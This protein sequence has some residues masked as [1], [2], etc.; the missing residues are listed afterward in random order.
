MKHF[1]AKIR[2][3]APDLP[4]EATDEEL[5]KVRYRMLKSESPEVTPQ[6]YWTVLG[7][8][9]GEPTD[10]LKT[11]P[12]VV[13]P[14]EG[15][16][17]PPK[18]AWE[19]A[20]RNNMKIL[21][22]AVEFGKQTIG[23]PQGPLVGIAKTAADIG[24][25]MA[26]GANSLITVPED[27]IMAL[28]GNSPAAVLQDLPT[29]DTKA[30]RERGYGDEKIAQLMG[31][32]AKV[33]NSLIEDIRVG[34]DK[35]SREVA[36]GVGLFL[37]FLA[38]PGAGLAVTKIGGSRLGSALA[39]S[40]AGGGG[41]MG[42]AAAASGASPEEV[43]TQTGTGALIGGLLHGAGEASGALVKKAYPG[44]T[45][46][47]T[48][49]PTTVDR[50]IP[51]P[52]RPVLNQPLGVNP[53]PDLGFGARELPITPETP[54]MG[55]LDPNSLVLPRPPIRGFDA[56]RGT[57]LPE[58]PQVVP[59]GLPIDP[60]LTVPE[61]TGPPMGQPPG[62]YEPPAVQGRIGSQP[63]P[64]V[65]PP[66][67]LPRRPNSALD[68]V[69]P[70]PE[71]Q[72][73]ARPI[74]RLSDYY[75]G[76]QTGPPP[77]V[78]ALAALKL[79]DP[80]SK[81]TPGRYA[82]EGTHLGIQPSLDGKRLEI[83]HLATK[84]AAIEGQPPPAQAALARVHA[85]ADRLAV[86]V[87]VMLTPA[88][89]ARGGKVPITELKAWY[90]QQGYQV[91][92]EGTGWVQVRRQP[93]PKNP[94]A[95]EVVESLSLEGPAIA[96][97]VA[98][99]ESV[100]AV[101][102]AG[103]VI[104]GQR[105]I[106]PIQLE[107]A[108][109]IEGIKPT[110]TSLATTVPPLK[111]TDL[112]LTRNL[113]EGRGILPG[114]ADRIEAR[115][116]SEGDAAAK[117]LNKSLRRLNSVIPG[118]IPPGMARD[119][120]IVTASFIFR[121]GLRSQRAIA[122]ALVEQFGDSIFPHVP[123]II[124]RA[125]D[126]L[127]KNLAGGPSMAKQ[128]KSMMDTYEM[129]KGTIG[130]YKGM[131]DFLQK[132]YGEDWKV[133]AGLIA[134]TSYKGSTEANITSALKAYG[135]YKLG[136]PFEGYQVQAVVMGLEAAARGEVFGGLKAQN[137]L[138]A[139]LGDVQAMALDR[140]VNRALGWKNAG[141]E[142]G[143]TSLS[144]GA[145]ALYSQI[146]RDVAKEVGVFPVNVQEALWGGQKIVDAI[147]REKVG[148]RGAS[149]KTGSFRFIDTLL[150][151]KMA[152]EDGTPRSP[153][154]WID[155]H[156]TNL[157]QLTDA[158]ESARI[159]QGPDG[160]VT[161]DPF[162]LKVD[163]SP[164]YIVTI[165]QQVI[166]VGA[167]TGSKLVAFR[168][169]WAEI[170]DKYPGI[171]LGHYQ[172]L[173]EDG[174]P[175]GKMSQ[176]LNILL[177][178]NPSNL[179]GAIELGK[180]NR[181]QAIGHIDANGNYTNH[182]TGYDPAVHGPQFPSRTT[183]VVDKMM[184]DLGVPSRDTPSQLSLW[185]SLFREPSGSITIP[186]NILANMVKSPATWLGQ[187]VEATKFT[188]EQIKAEC[189]A[190]TFKPMTEAGVAGMVSITRGGLVWRYVDPVGPSYNTMELVM[191]LKGKD[192]VANLDRLNGMEI[193]DGFSNLERIKSE[194]GFARFRRPDPIPGEAQASLTN[195]MLKTGGEIV[196]LSALSARSHGTGLNSFWMLPNGRIV[197]TAWMHSRHADMIAKKISLTKPKGF[198]GGE[199][200]AGP[201]VQAL[202]NMGVIRI[203]ASGT[204]VA[205]DLSAKITFQQRAALKEI[206]STH[207]D[208]AA[209]ISDDLGR[210]DSRWNGGPP[211]KFLAR[212]TGEE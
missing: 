39:S 83:T 134:A 38:G 140:M 139:L 108:L 131:K 42:G 61:N 192:R 97:R 144:D 112:T 142:G 182:P 93:T 36:N 196:P 177:P 100:N 141:L 63:P 77:V 152:R 180:A 206:F 110:E 68:Y 16:I 149:S 21:Q 204:M 198:E 103:N 7:R 117:R 99:V 23:H 35:T 85:E 119:A 190:G 104:E 84:Q 188:P 147:A 172:M 178:D 148:G 44:P 166:D 95:P 158:S 200:T 195:A 69:E 173:G 11:P 209:Q 79:G 163:K 127:Q 120:A 92:D 54:R 207:E 185:G 26:E 201:R 174:K 43:V 114:L 32:R 53:G 116:T 199:Q 20:S 162:T 102:A 137:Y 13:P 14:T 31:E 179:A 146:L 80:L 136:L 81:K 176:D 65:A 205:A 189:D 133:M 52:E 46:P 45:A 138:A 58:G 82:V 25:S 9:Y 78:D 107:L 168:K 41:F 210:I 211:H 90:E 48:P 6:E 145:Y 194:S 208:W 17:P 40:A 27:M 129:G 123:M 171:K 124:K 86:P 115:L 73:P 160:G 8:M 37:S 154:E 157:R 156:A 191:N 165:D 34:T 202:L 64:P 118:A 125:E 181:Q 59:E 212:A 187:A 106:R 169:R 62:G 3:E 75:P 161:V 10:T 72:P 143:I 70:V 5:L 153:A 67:P 122:A 89:T 96:E 29:L 24:V 71:V 18:N 159:G 12:P 4:P 197:R 101:Q 2:A 184:E 28:T 183:A 94:P 66:P 121:K 30:M 76:N 126:I 19:A 15:A 105:L 193:H 98:G 130:W 128:M 51:P 132:N 22:N 56:E 135:Q 33:A 49:I 186:S 170:I 175:N 150:K 88:E 109:S 151:N 113:M 1:A 164:G 167:A 50:P 47:G 91:V 111:R 203:Q 60:R 74:E 57:M 55:G 87:D 155:D